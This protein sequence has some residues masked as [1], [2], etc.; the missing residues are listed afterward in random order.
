MG[1]CVCREGGGG[2]E[3][4]GRGCL[5]GSGLRN[6]IDHFHLKRLST[7]SFGQ[8]TETIC[9]HYPPVPTIQP[10]GRNRLKV[11][12]KELL[13]LFNISGNKK[14]PHSSFP[15]YLKKKSK[16]LQISLVS[17]GLD[18]CK[19]VP[20]FTVFSP[21]PFP[22]PSPVPLPSPHQLLS[23]SLFSLELSAC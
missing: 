6:N 15:P 9:S 12:V 2:V 8:R 13:M 23:G 20:P 19:T 11:N 14:T 21:F 3:R 4:L 10:A 17:A 7:P 5:D 22:P 16:N 1:V 18:R